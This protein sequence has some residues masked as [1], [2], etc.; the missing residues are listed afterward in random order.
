[1]RYLKEKGKRIPA[2]KL[3]QAAEKVK[4]T[5]T[6]IKALESEFYHPQANQYPE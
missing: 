1:V 3:I 5:S 6:D 4:V 2:A